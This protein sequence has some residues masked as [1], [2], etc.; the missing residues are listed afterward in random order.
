MLNEYLDGFNGVLAPT[1]AWNGIP[2]INSVSVVTLGGEHGALNRQ[3]SA[4]A[5]RL[6]YLGTTAGGTKIGVLPS[7]TGGL[8]SFLNDWV[9]K[10]PLPSDYDTN[11]NYVARVQ[12]LATG[13]HFTQNGALIW[14]IPDRLFVGDAINNDGTFPNVSKDWLTTHQNGLKVKR[15]VGTSATG[16]TTSGS[17]VVTFTAGGITPSI[18]AQFFGDYAIPDGTTVVSVDSTTQITLSANATA[19]TTSN[20]FY[21]NNTTTTVGSGVSAASFG[22]TNSNPS[23]AIGALW[24]S[25]SL[26]FTSVGTACIGLMAAAI[27]N[28]ATLAT[29]AWGFYVEGQRTNSTVGQTVGTEISMSSTGSSEIVPNSFRQSTTH[30]LQISGGCGLAGVLPSGTQVDLGAVMYV[31]ASPRAFHTGIVFGNNSIAGTDGIT[32]T[33]AA[34]VLSM[35]PGHALEWKNSAEDLVARIL[36]TNTDSAA[37]TE[38]RFTAAGV[39]MLGNAGQPLFLVN[40]IASAV[41]YISVTPAATGAAPN[42]SAVGTDADIDLRLIPKGAGVVRFGTLTANADAPISGYITI[43]DDGGTIRKLAVIT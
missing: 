5:A 27:N 23:S 22:L 43:K 16:V 35:A 2:K 20:T 7:G 41:N 6:D 32:V 8:G 39:Q 13:Q 29:K 15:V 12:A 1:A 11:A 24:A 18:E 37:K 10:R 3:A 17:P 25:Q 26:N 36:T 4:I 30:A 19:T 42:V 38:L 28:N 21:S 9:S 40:H 14:R 33:T 31:A 34:P